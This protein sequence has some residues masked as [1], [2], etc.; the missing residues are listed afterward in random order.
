MPK[1]KFDEHQAGQNA[2]AEDHLSDALSHSKKLLLRAL[3]KARDFERPKLQKRQ[4]GP[5]FKGRKREHDTR[6][7]AEAKALEVRPCLL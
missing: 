1:R 6:L 2:A 7:V 5:V 3:T 4:K